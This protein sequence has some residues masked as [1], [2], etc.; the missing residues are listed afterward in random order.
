[1]FG[2]WQKCSQFLLP[3]YCLLCQVNF[4]PHGLCEACEA[5]LA[6]QQAC[7]PI[8]ADPLE[9]S[10]PC[11]RCLN[12]PPN[13]D[14]A[15]VPLH[16]QGAVQQLITQLKFSEK[17]SCA[18]VLSHLMIKHLI[19]DKNFIKPDLLLPVPLH[20]KR[21][22]ERGFNQALEIAKPLAKALKIP[23]ERH[24]LFKKIFTM[25]QVGQT[26]AVRKKNLKNSF[27]LR[28]AL[29]GKH[30]GIVDDVMTTGSTVNEIAKLLKAQGATRVT[31]LAVARTGR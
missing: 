15:I 2:C 8:C 29:A 12:H 7:C 27:A 23:F 5:E 4:A 25:P 3:N 10:L 30:V 1:M 13:F 26:F 28:K 11:G 6:W 24:L 19:Q 18:N 9:I 14:Q 16:Y 22:Q 17:L 20:A 21:I 31:V